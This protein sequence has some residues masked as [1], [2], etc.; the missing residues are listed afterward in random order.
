MTKKWLRLKPKSLRVRLTGWYIILLGCTLVG[1]SSY[2]YSQ[3]KQSLLI[4]INTNLNI[5]TSEVINTLIAEDEHF[6]LKKTQKTEAFA[7]DLIKA[8][9]AVRLLSASGKVVDGFGEYQEF[10]QLIP[11]QSGYSDF[12]DN[13]GQWRMYSHPIHL[14]SGQGWIQVAQSL[15]PINQ[16]SDHLL[17]LMLISCPLVL[18]LAA[19]GGLFLADQ[20]LRPINTII[21]TAQA[22]NPH[23]ITRR[24]NYR[25]SI[26]EVGRLAMTLDRMLDRLEEAFEHQQRFTG[27][28]SHE[29]RTPL[30]VIKGRIGVALSQLRTPEDYQETLQALEQ[31]VDRLIRLANSLLFLTRLEQK[32]IDLSPIDLSELLVILVEQFQL[33]AEPRKIQLK[34]SIEKDLFILGNSD[35]LTSLLLNLLDNAVKY[36][37]DNGQVWVKTQTDT[38][39]VHI[40]VINTGKGI[41]PTDLPHLFKRFYRVESDR[42][43]HTGGTGLGLAIA[44][45]IVRLH[46]GTIT[47]ESQLNQ[48]TTFTVSF[49]ANS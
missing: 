48:A 45:E 14:S 9:F 28:A 10:P 33:M 41:A 37:P 12:R 30:T 16:A 36:T 23:D 25:G 31:E 40:Q 18:L 43:R 47:V 42:S 1:F 26:D 22:I 5:T 17:F 15:E 38:E 6:A 13:S 34:E 21:S 7:H 44:Y 24:I 11:K 19:L 39:K 46:G 49:V 27:D 32:N 4:Q 29:L 35:Y 8:G 2:L 3:L 20:A